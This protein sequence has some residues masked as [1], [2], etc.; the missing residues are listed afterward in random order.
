MPR[1]TV[2]G[3]P[4][5]EAVEAALV[6]QRG[7]RDIA[8][9]FRL[10]KSALE[11]HKANHLPATLVKAQ[12]AEV[13]ADADSLLSQVRDLQRKALA[14]LAKAEAAGELRTALQAIGQ[15]RGNLELLAKLLGE[16]DDRPQVNVLLAPE[17]QAVRSAL[18]AAL[19]PFPEA[20][21]AVAARLL[22]LEA[23]NGPRG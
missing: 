8:G 23:G 18:L 17:W 9:Q 4:D 3:H 7:L 16:L 2:C 19:G 10:S 13:V 20:R 5:R 15:A 22:E 6:A 12:H 11:R 1:C 21:A 14:I